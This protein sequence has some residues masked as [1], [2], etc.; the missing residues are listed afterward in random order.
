MVA[1]LRVVLQAGPKK[2][3]E[4]MAIVIKKYQNESRDNGVLNHDLDRQVSG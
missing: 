1:L 2:K 4:L 3:V